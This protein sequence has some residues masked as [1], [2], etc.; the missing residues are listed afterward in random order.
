MNEELER[1]GYSVPSD[2]ELAAVD[3]N[4]LAA[5]TEYPVLCARQRSLEMGHIAAE[6]LQRRIEHPDADWQHVRLDYDLNFTP[7][8]EK[9]ASSSSQADCP[10]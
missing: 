10:D 1:L 3:D 7:G 8:G 2:I 6:L 4:D 5:E 9:A